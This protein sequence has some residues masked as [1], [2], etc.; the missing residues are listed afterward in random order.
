[1]TFSDVPRERRPLRCSKRSNAI[2]RIAAPVSALA[3]SVAA[4]RFP[5][6]NQTRITPSASVLTLN[7]RTVPISV[8]VS[9][10]T[11]AAPAAIAG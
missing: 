1:M 8:N 10:A 3:N 4:P 11:S 5:E 7:K 2:S 6:P 9:I